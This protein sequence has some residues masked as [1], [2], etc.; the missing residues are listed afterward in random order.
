MSKIHILESDN[1][2]SY[3]AVIHFPIPPGNNS[4]A[5]S[6]K[7][8]GLESGKTGTTILKIGSAPGN[9]TQSEYDSIIAGD[10]VEIVQAINPG[11]NPSN[12][13]AEALCDI[14]IA[15]W[16]ADTARILKYYGHTI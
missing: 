8:C 1:A 13:A 10:T 16:S 11:L 2:N 14:A 3:K 4:V 15:N 7:A 12:Q 9:I 5:M 6:W